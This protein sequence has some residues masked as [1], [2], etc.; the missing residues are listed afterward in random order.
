MEVD[1]D[2]VKTSQKQRL[3]DFDGFL[4]PLLSIRK[5]FRLP[6]LAGQA[7]LIPVV[8]TEVKGKIV[9]LVVDRL[10]GQQET[11]IRPLGRPLNKIGGLSG[12]TVLGN[13]RTI[14]LLD[15]GNIV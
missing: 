12:T 4:I 6:P 3:I 8:V 9:G 1:R 14:F 2:T 5:I 13:G 10:V 11:F 15:V 7:K